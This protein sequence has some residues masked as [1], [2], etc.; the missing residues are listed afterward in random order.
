MVL[1]PL[2]QCTIYSEQSVPEAWGLY[3]ESQLMLQFDWAT[4]QRNHVPCHRSVKI[5][6][7]LGVSSGSVCARQCWVRKRMNTD[8]PTLLPRSYLLSAYFSTFLLAPSFISAVVPCL[9]YRI[10]LMFME[11][12][13]VSWSE[14][15]WTVFLL[16]V[17]PVKE[18]EHEWRPSFNCN[19]ST[20]CSS[21]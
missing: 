4:V 13:A 5:S 3:T 14:H 6:C 20:L 15:T 1:L 16:S 8:L 7:N 12:W 9:C 2:S 10:L 18:R 17:N 11:G 21:L 19:I